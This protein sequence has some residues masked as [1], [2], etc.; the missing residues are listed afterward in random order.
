MPEHDPLLTFWHAPPDALFSS[1]VV[2]QARKVSTALLERERWQNTGPPY[3]KVRGRVLY[4][5]GDV[6]KWIEE[7]AERFAGTRPQ[8]EDSPPAA[9]PAETS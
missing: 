1:A 4:R 8:T 6:L 9:Q 5:K 7:I 3:L 2:A